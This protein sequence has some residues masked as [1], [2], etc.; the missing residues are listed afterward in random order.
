MVKRLIRV[1]V[2]DVWHT[3]EVEDPPRY[4]FQIIVDGE[5]IQVEV[6]AEGAEALPRPARPSSA[7]GAGKNVGLTGISQEGERIIR[8]PMPGRIV[9]V[10]VKVWDRVEPGKEVCV[11]ETMKM[12]QSVLLARA[13]AVRA[14]FIRPGQIVAVGDPLIQME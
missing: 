7:A 11:L 3:V 6:E 8:A 14:V 12:E 5:A 1:K 9:S 2:K 10:S 4:P 13:G